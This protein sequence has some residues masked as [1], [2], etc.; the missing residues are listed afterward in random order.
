MGKAIRFNSEA[1]IEKLSNDLPDNYQIGLHQVEAMEGI[2]KENSKKMIRKNVPSTYLRKIKPE[3]YC[4]SIMKSGL[5]N[6]WDDIKFTLMNFGSVEE[7]RNSIERREQFLNYEYEREKRKSDLY[8]VIVAIP[9]QVK[10]DN[11]EYFLG[12]LAHLSDLEAEPD[13]SMGKRIFNKSNIPKEFI[14]GYIHKH[15]GIIDFKANPKYINMKSLQEQRSFFQYLVKEKGLDTIKNEKRRM[16]KDED[17]NKDNEENKKGPV[18]AFKKMQIDKLKE[19]FSLLEEQEEIETRARASMIPYKKFNFLQ[20]YL[21]KRKEY[22]D[23]IRDVQNAQ[24]EQEEV[25]SSDKVR[26]GEI[27]KK[28]SA[29][30]FPTI[31]SISQKIEELSNAT[32]F[33][34]LGVED[35]N[36]AI[37]NLI[38]QG[39]SPNFESYEQAFEMAPEYLGKNAEFMKKAI[40]SNLEFIKYD[41][42]ND[43]ELYKEAI[44]MRIK[45]V[46]GKDDI[47]VDIE[48]E[49]LEELKREI[50]S[51]KKV[52]EG[53]YKVPHKF[54]FEEIRNN[55]SSNKLGGYWYSTVDGVYDKEFGE[56]LEKLYE[57]P[58]L[59][60]G[61]HG[62]DENDNR[63]SDI[64][65]KGLRNS[66]QMADVALNRTV[67]FG[68]QLTFTKLLNYR[69]PHNGLESET[70]II[71]TL[72]KAAL[73]PKN[74]V[75]IWGSMEK[76]GSYNYIL[77]KYIYGLYHSKKDGGNRSIIKNNSKQQEQYKY[78]KYDYQSCKS[79][80]YEINDQREF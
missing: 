42:T 77:P 65:S 49:K 57:N 72:P 16:N 8:D 55:A 35:S 71:L 7:I 44:Q 23:Y 64:F 3:D 63:E 22:K 6:R 26:L 48:L 59:M 75:P 45:M 14:Y 60:I 10:V 17:D 70:A 67:A 54:M 33:K 46:K 62:M 12:H 56:E 53:K 73:D 61:V 1:W 18:Q 24:K 20:K 2:A 52:M 37:E 69:L 19:I 40:R 39:I 50:D 11:E 25:K 27:K 43:E 36:K 41:K 30:G 68:K 58:N 76:T 21:L 28:L 9:S 74:P 78:L 80:L 4:K 31:S 51:P 47:L 38:K 5:M 15:D 66:M 32:T 34:E 13:M 79:G 29:E